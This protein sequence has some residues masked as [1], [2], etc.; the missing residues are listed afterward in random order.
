M[1][2]IKIIR[3]LFPCDLTRDA[4]RSKRRKSESSVRR[5]TKIEGNE[6]QQNGIT[7]ATPPSFL[8]ARALADHGLPDRVDPLSIEYLMEFDYDDGSFQLDI[9]TEVLMAIQS[10]NIDILTQHYTTQDRLVAQ[11]NS[12]GET[13]LHLACHWGSVAVVKSLLCDARMC[14]SVLDRQGRSPLHSLC[15]A[16]NRSPLHC[17]TTSPSHNHL[18]AMR[19]LL[20][21]KATL[22][23][24]KD[25]QGNVPLEYI[26]QSGGITNKDDHSNAL[27]HTVV[28][29][30]L[31]SERV[32]D[33]V[34]E[35][36]SHRMEH[37]RSGRRRSALEKLNTLL[38]FSGI[39]AAIMETGLSV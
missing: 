32:V 21:E 34:V 12:Q 10:D 17:P 24:Y 35:E 2:A 31:C 39:E 20:R 23:I 15:L 36:M 9:P 3:E 27:F 13:L 11:R 25:K 4:P 38:D 26:Q 19:L 37:S 7:C 14:V 28:N 30:I 22:I 8:V 16:M 1:T 29:E 18:E 33:R 5:G 6:H